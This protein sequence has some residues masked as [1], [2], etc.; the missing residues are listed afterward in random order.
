MDLPIKNGGFD[1]LL[2]KRLPEDSPT[3]GYLKIGILWSLMELGVAAYLSN[4]Q[5]KQ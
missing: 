2:R 4:F 1:P 5:P 3:L